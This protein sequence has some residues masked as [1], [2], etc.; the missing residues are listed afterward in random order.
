MKDRKNPA[1]LM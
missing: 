1:D